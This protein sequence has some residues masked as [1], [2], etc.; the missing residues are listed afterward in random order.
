MGGAEWVGPE[1][2]RDE[3][4]LFSYLVSGSLHESERV[5]EDVLAGAAGGPPSAEPITRE[6]MYALSAEACLQRLA[7]RPRRG[8]PSLTRPPSDPSSPPDRDADASAWVE[9]FPDSLFP[10]RFA[11]DAPVSEYTARESSS[12]FMAAALQEVT[13]LARAAFVL[14]D[15][16][17]WRTAAAAEV[18]GSEERETGAALDEARGTVTRSYRAELGRR[19]PPPER[20]ATSLSMRYLYPWETADLE[21][22]L[23]RLTADVT[24]QRPP[25]PSWYRGAEAFRRFA[26]E[27]LLP[28][29]SR[30]RWRLLPLRASGQ[31]GFGAYRVDSTRRVYLAHSIQ[32][33]FFDGG[34]VSEI[35]CFADAGLFPL[36]GL[37]PEV[38][39]QGS[40]E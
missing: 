12:L 28:E 16:L 10:E 9:P 13:P 21:G 26:S 15:L 30:G 40:I 11:L 3:L 14:A 25:S 4:R 17:C 18:L 19:E 38:A 37:L 29:G 34:L 24:F 35:V 31:L 22:L 7:G 33:L 20:D 6:S 8:L 5:V 32:V 39:V 27:H 1:Q 2:Y 36:F 23:A